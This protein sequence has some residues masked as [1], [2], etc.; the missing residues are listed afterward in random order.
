MREHR[1][2]TLLQWSKSKIDRLYE[3]AKGLS[4]YIYETLEGPDKIRTLQLHVRKGRI[5]CSLRQISFLDSGYQA[6]SYVWGSEEKPFKAIVLDDD[7]KELGYISL[8]ANVQAALCD[9]RDAKKVKSK[10]FWI[11]QICINQQGDEK[12]H[13]VRLWVK[14]TEMPRG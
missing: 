10:V 14:Y 13:Q 7:G 4:P 1:R 9:L 3:K 11:D 6:L 12:N 5:E 8:T 2:S